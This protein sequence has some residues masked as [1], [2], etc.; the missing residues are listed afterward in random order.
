MGK[1]CIENQSR[2][3]FHRT[4]LIY[5]LWFRQVCFIDQHNRND[6]SKIAQLK[7]ILDRKIGA[8]FVGM[9]FVSYLK[10]MN[11]YIICTNQKGSRARF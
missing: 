7:C 4:W 2:F 1:S 3:I 5:F 11:M 9:L 6:F 8:F 10:A